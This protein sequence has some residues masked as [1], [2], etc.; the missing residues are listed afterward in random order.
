MPTQV[1]SSYVYTNRLAL[2]S[3]KKAPWT[4]LVVNLVYILFTTIQPKKGTVDLSRRYP[5]KEDL[6]YV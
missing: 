1:I 4:C 6:V 3:P 2:Y 5:K